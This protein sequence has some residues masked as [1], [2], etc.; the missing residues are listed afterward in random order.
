MEVCEQ[1]TLQ[2]ENVLYKCRKNM[3]LKN[4][5]NIIINILCVIMWHLQYVIYTVVREYWKK[6]K[7]RQKKHRL[8]YVIP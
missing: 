1:K 8:S 5:L 3:I 7:E 6:K 2:L 4:K